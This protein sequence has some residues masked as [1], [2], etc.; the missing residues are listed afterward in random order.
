MQFAGLC[1]LFYLYFKRCNNNYGEYNELKD[2]LLE[3]KK[4]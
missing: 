4:E 3:I 2:K 1:A